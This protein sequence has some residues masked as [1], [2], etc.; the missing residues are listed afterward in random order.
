MI[1]EIMNYRYLKAY[2]L[3]SKPG[4]TPN[5]LSY[6]LV[7]SIIIVLLLYHL[8]LK[9][10]NKNIKNTPA[11]EFL[12]I[13]AYMTS[14]KLIGRIQNADPDKFKVAVFIFIEGSGWWTKPNFDNPLTV[15][16]SDCTWTVDIINADRDQN[17]SRIKAYLLP[18]GI[19]PP[20]L[21]GTACLPEILKTKSIVDIETTRKLRTIFFSGYEWQ[22][23]SSKAPVGP[24]PNLFSDSPENVWIDGHNNLHLKITHRDEQWSCAEVVLSKSL[25]YGKYIFKLASNI[26]QINENAIL[27]IFTWDN[28]ACTEHYREIDFE[29]S[30]WGNANDP[31]NAQY[32][33]Q[34]WDHPGNTKRWH[35]P[36]ACISST[37]VL[38]WNDKKI[39]FRSIRGHDIAKQTDSLIYSWSYKGA[40]IPAPGSESIRMNLWLRNGKAPSDGKEVDVL[41]S[42]FEY[43]PL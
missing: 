15:I 38:D 9:A 35:L 4:S 28:D 7:F 36:I 40:N 17:A 13:P 24:G 37:H 32:V 31:N 43:L 42:K 33:I 6:L 19:T 41:I 34:P 14:E 27:G 20:L 30:R 1:K 22:V 2:L 23:K 29:F 25:G 5:I 16:Q 26:G 11:L 12:K 21:G 18:N 39:D 10:Y 8:D 3:N